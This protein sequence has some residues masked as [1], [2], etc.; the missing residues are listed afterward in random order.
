MAGIGIVAIGELIAEPYIASG[1][2][3]RIMTEY[4][5]PPVGIYEVRPSGQK[6]VR[7]VP[8]LID[9]MAAQFA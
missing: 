7:K 4:Q 9:L 1:A 3:L 5:L 6:A 2:L 8:V